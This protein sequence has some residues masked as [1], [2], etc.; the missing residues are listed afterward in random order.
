MYYINYT[1]EIRND[2]DMKEILEISDSLTLKMWSVGPA[3]VAQ[4]LSVY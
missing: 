1:M 2:I 4:W 3:A